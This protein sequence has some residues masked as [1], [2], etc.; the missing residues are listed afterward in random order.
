MLSRAWGKHLRHILFL[1]LIVNKW[2][3][4]RSGRLRGL[5]D[6][7][8]AP[9]ATCRTRSLSDANPKPAD[10]STRR[11]DRSPTLARLG[12]VLYWSTL[13]TLTHWPRLM[14]SSKAPPAPNDPV[15]LLQLDKPIHAGAF[16][17]LACL[18]IRARLFDRIMESPRNL[19]LTTLL[20]VAYAVIDEWTQGFSPERTVS[21]GDMLANTM[22][23]VGVYLWFAGVPGL[24]GAGL[25]QPGRPR[26]LGPGWGWFIA[27]G[28]LGLCLG[29][30]CWRGLGDGAAGRAVAGVLSF[31]LA[32]ALFRALVG[33]G[34][35]GVWRWWLMMGVVVG[36]IGAGV[37]VEAWR[38][39]GGGRM[40]FSYL[41]AHHLGAAGLIFVLAV[42][43]DRRG[44]LDSGA[45]PGASPGADSDRSP[46]DGR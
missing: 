41:F 17:L 16:G 19:R 10:P 1:N 33:L 5:A 28:L 32:L 39:I 30:S 23:I 25:A 45:S 15:Q 22:G 36:T 3:I 44:P 42:L 14:S 18:L 13:A 11:R 8:D 37:V 34:A 27:P 29:V 2:C 43:A 26:G 7:L 4:A 46:G 6:N 12:L 31:A 9:S 20:A 40:S 38:M 24:G 21:A 35:G